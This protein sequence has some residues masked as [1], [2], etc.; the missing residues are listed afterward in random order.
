MYPRSTWDNTSGKLILGNP[1][2]GL[3]LW[4]KKI[5]N[6]DDSWHHKILN[7]S[8]SN[9]FAQSLKD[10][11]AAED[12]N[13]CLIIYRKENQNKY[14]VKVDDCNKKKVV[15]CKAKSNKP[16]NNEL[17]ETFPCISKQSNSRKKR[18]TAFDNF[19]S[20]GFGEKEYEEGK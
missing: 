14:I 20:E 19:K 16:D 13:K 4:I 5:D 11:L 10:A 3:E 6:N 1:I 7:I 18:Q 15:V 9:E 17:E 12:E 2:F 8:T